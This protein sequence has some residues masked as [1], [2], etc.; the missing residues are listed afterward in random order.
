MTRTLGKILPPQSVTPQTQDSMTEPSSPTVDLKALAQHLGLSKGTISRALN[1]YPE[2]AERTRSR[3]LQAANELGYK[4]NRAARRL[5][6]GRNDL[7]SYI[8]VGSDW[9]T[10]ERSFLS[11]LSSTL[12]LRGYG[13][14]VSLAD[15]MEHAKDTMQQLIDDKRVDGFVFSTLFPSDERVALAA[16]NCVPGA[17][18]GGSAVRS[19]HTSEMPVI[20]IND[21]AV[22]D[23][24][25]DY[26]NSMGHDGFA[27][28][29]CDAPQAVQQFHS[30]T[31][32]ASCGNRNTNFFRDIRSD[33]ER[34]AD[35]GTAQFEAETAASLTHRAERILDN[36]PSRATA[37]FCGCE[38]TVVALYMAARDRGLS[39]PE[40]LS[41]IG[42]GS[43]QL[44]SWLSGGLST[45]SWSLAEAGRLA[46]E[47]V[48]AQVEGTEAPDLNAG[49]EAQFVARSSH[50]PAPRDVSTL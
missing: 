43:S 20:G 16:A 25:V 24:L 34:H 45:V 50:G 46:A 40:E 12:S 36:K 18:I 14:M 6:T 27:Y 3:V 35:K 38:R 33:S 42:I 37:V 49:I 2:I 31:L 44:A 48:V 4:P 29:G 9:M 11:A 8:G 15:T 7:V 28:F 10:I 22:L 30:E 26:L 39:V 1:G 13:L 5:A 17:I 19:S 47:C 32:A 21:T 41:I 23:G